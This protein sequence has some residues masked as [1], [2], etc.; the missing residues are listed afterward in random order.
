MANMNSISCA[1]TCGRRLS[2]SARKVSR[3]APSATRV[4]ASFPQYVFRATGISAFTSRITRQL[5]GRTTEF[6]LLSERCTLYLKMSLPLWAN[7]GKQKLSG[8]PW[9]SPNAIARWQSAERKNE[10]CDDPPCN[11]EH[12]GPGAR[13]F[14]YLQLFPDQAC[15][16]AGGHQ[17]QNGE[18]DRRTNPGAAGH[19]CCGDALLRIVHAGSGGDE[20]S[21]EHNTIGDACRAKPPRDRTVS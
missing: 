1:T 9:P 18:A 7:S 4:G 17:D 20:H 2:V 3:V 15:F 5:I 6:A 11:S 8:L 12:N 14:G 21:R 13:G 10:S 19:D 16:R